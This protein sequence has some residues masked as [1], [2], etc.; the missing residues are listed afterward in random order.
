MDGLDTN[1]SS[2]DESLNRNAGQILMNRT[3]STPT[4]MPPMLGEGI[5]VAGLNIG[6]ALNKLIKKKPRARL[7]KMEELEKGGDIQ[8]PQEAVDQ[9]VGAEATFDPSQRESLEGFAQESQKPSLEPLQGR[10]AERNINLDFYE[11][12]DAKRMMALI[13]RGQNG[14][15]DMPQRQVQ[16]NEKTIALAKNAEVQ[17]SAMNKTPDARWSPEELVFMHKR[18]EGQATE[19]NVLAKRINQQIENG[20]QPSDEALVELDMKRTAF[21]ATEKTVSGAVADAGRLLQSLQAVAKA[22]SGSQYYKTLSKVA[23]DSGGQ[24]RLIDN[25]KLLGD[26]E[27][28]ENIS[29]AANKMRVWDKVLEV[30]YNMMLSGVRTHVANVG[31]SLITG[32]WEKTIVKG[33]QSTANFGEYVFR[34]VMPKIS[35]MPEEDRIRF[36]Y[37]MPTELSSLLIGMREGILLAGRVIKGEELGEGKLYNEMGIKYKPQDLPESKLGKGLTLPTRALEAEDAFFRAMYMNTSLQIQALRKSHAYT[38]QQKAYDMLIEHPTDEMLETAKAYSEKLIFANDPSVYGSILG[39]TAKMAADIR[40]KH[41]FFQTLIPFLKTPANV[42]SYAFEQSAMTQVLAPVKTAQKFAGTPQERAEVISQWMIA[43]GLFMLLSDMYDDGTITGQGSKSSAVRFAHEANGWQPNSVRVGDKYLSLSR[44]DP[45]GLTVNMIASTYDAYYGADNPH[46]RT[47]AL[48]GGMLSVTEAL[49]DRS[50]LSSLKDF[51]SVTQGGTF[52][53]L[54]MFATS[55]ATSV[56]TAGFIRDIREMTDPYERDMSFDGDMYG[57]AVRL[58]K[59]LHNATPFMTSTSPPKVD[60]NGE[61]VVKAG[62]FLWRGLVPIKMT[63]VNTTDKVSAAYIFHKTPV[64]RPHYVIGVPN[65]S[66][67]LN[68]LQ[69]DG[70]QGWLYHDYQIRVGKWRHKLVKEF[71]DSSDFKDLTDANQIGA[72]SIA[73]EIITKLVAKGK[74][75]ATLEMFNDLTTMTEYTPEI[76]GKNGKLW[77]GE[78][79]QL[80]PV[81]IDEMA[82]IQETIKLDIVEEDFKKRWEALK[83]QKYIRLPSP[84]QLGD[85][86][87]ILK[88]DTNDSPIIRPMR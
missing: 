84:Q 82:Q 31:G 33:A 59:Q 44:L 32:L 47:A 19:L 57:I 54:A 64:A 69:A 11:G 38:N 49:S 51:L 1:A 30:R 86:P 71:L 21:I 36:F 20:V 66:I 41:P 18:M 40:S 3:S 52:K 42:I 43:G 76:K 58:K 60:A 37:E 17:L 15:V 75:F 62:N 4:A 63:S 35:P 25:A 6:G 61:Y 87:S 29:S 72:N 23:Q 34:E 67:K 83:D 26:A 2:I 85:L 16:T 70:Q 8:V 50:Y 28:L 77:K 10:T 13:N 68:L 14:F 48:L 65:T 24:Q 73:A 45:L 80:D 56:G 79:I 27:G 12:E 22:G 88:S 46:D 7:K 81:S 39:G 9:P 55:Q 78:T 53:Q 74:Q 5:Q